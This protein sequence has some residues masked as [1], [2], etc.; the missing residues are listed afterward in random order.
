ML[1]THASCSR[2]EIL[3]SILAIAQRAVTGTSGHGGGGGGGG[4]DDD[5]TT[6]CEWNARR[7]FGVEGGNQRY[8]NWSVEFAVCRVM[9]DFQLLGVEVIQM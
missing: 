8:W 9:G 4:G 7:V 3:R 6:G 1:L 2:S 5:D